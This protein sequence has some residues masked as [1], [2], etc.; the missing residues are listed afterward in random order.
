MCVGKREGADREERDR[1][2]ENKVAK[3]GKRDMKRKRNVLRHIER[4]SQTGRQ[5]G[6]QINRKLGRI[7]V[8]RGLGETM[9]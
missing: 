9:R 7:K 4:H 2:I 3:Q 8:R 5:I 6:K 1:G